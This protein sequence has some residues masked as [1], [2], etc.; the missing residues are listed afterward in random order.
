VICVSED[1]RRAGAAARVVADGRSEVV[2]NGVHVPPPAPRERRDGRP[3]VGTIA[4]LAPQKGI[5][6]LLAAVPSLLQA[7]PG[8]RVVIV[9]GGPLEDELRAR[10]DELGLGE[11]V[12]F[13]GPVE[14]ARDLLPSFDVFVLPSRWEGMPIA[15]LE[16]RAA[17]LP[18]VATEVGGVRDIVA[19][20]ADGRVVPVEDA[21]A[22]A[23]ALAELAGDEELR[24]RWGR[25]AR[26]RVAREFPLDAMVRRT[27][28]LYLRT[29]LAPELTHA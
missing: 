9:G 8:A 29:I 25:I 11:A 15:L 5:D 19:D 14:N 26:E 16:A 21:D 10:A 7:A 13:L 23:G 6:V 3:V 27:E 22:L 1:E 20:G 17:G 4:R 2:V 12:S 24:E 18:C 28:L